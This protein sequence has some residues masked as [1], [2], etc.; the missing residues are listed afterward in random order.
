MKSLELFPRNLPRRFFLENWHTSPTQKYETLS[1]THPELVY[2]A[3]HCCAL[4]IGWLNFCS[5]VYVS[6]W[7]AKNPGRH[8][9]HFMSK[10]HSQRSSTY[11]YN[12]SNIHGYQCPISKY[13]NNDCYRWQL[14]RIH[15]SSQSPAKIGRTSNRKKLWAKYYCCLP[16]YTPMSLFEIHKNTWIMVKC[17]WIG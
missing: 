9:A 6:P 7:S 14:Y 15:I 5:R 2:Q 11:L 13:W 1:L 8:F 12:T 3:S 17:F 10:I 4:L 16:T